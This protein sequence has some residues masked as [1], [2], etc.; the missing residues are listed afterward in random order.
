MDAVGKSITGH[1]DGGHEIQLQQRQV[2]KV[3]L[4]QGFLLEMGMH[5]PDTSQASGVHAVCFKGWNQDA[6]GVSNDDAHNPPL[7]ID[8]Q[9]DLALQLMGELGH[10]PDQFSR[11]QGRGLNAASV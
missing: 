7:A 6:L 3:V 11:Y 2:R 10:V 1:G 8:D 5:A 4:G 9:T